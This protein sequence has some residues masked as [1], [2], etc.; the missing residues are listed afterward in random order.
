MTPYFGDMHIK[1]C[2]GSKRQ[3]RHPPAC[4]NARGG[5]DHKN[6]KMNLFILKWHHNQNY[7]GSVNSFCGNNYDYRIKTIRARRGVKNMKRLIEAYE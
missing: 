7:K 3:A 5:A 2:N 1:V 6:K 4:R